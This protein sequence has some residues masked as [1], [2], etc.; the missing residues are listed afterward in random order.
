M[1]AR[2]PFY[3]VVGNN[4]VVRL[5][6]VATSFNAA[7]LTELGI[8]AGTANGEPPAGKNLVGSG[9]QAALER[10]CFGVNLVYAATATKNQTVKVVCSS[11][12]ADTV[13][14]GARSKTY[15]SKNIVDVRVP[16]R[17]IYQ[18]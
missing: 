15:R 6:L 12:K 18:T 8:T 16:R 14:A 13:F 10:G 9:K 3:I 11:Q 1:P 5:Q 4:N 2:S 7:L 17:R